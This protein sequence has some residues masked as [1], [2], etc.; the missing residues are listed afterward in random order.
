MGF[1]SFSLHHQSCTQPELQAQQLHY[2]V[3]VLKDNMSSETETPTSNQRSFQLI[4]VYQKN[5]FSLFLSLS[6]IFLP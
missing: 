6:S 5:Q 4:F 2:S 1:C 3:F